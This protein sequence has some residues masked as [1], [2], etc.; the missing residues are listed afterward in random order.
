MIQMI[1]T[2]FLHLRLCAVIALFLILSTVQLIRAEENQ[3]NANL[4]KLGIIYKEKGLNFLSYLYNSAYFYTSDNMEEKFNA[5]I[6]ALNVC[7]KDKRT[8]EASAI[9]E[10]NIKSYPDKSL[11]V[12]NYY[13][14]TLLLSGNFKESLKLAEDHELLKENPDIT[15]IYISFALAYH[16]KY[17]QSAEILEKI[18]PSFPGFDMRKKLILELNAKPVSEKN[19]LLAGILSAI[20]PGSGQLY[21]GAYF[22]ALNSFGFT[23]LTGVAAA[24][25]WHHELDHNKKKRNYI[26]PI[27][28]STVFAIFY[29][30]NINN[31]VSITRKVNADH[32]N[33][34]QDKII[35]DFNILISDDSIF[36]NT[37]ISLH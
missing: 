9:Y 28:F 18:S 11:T 25:A 35:K 8:K 30:A 3:E 4:R 16:S 32:A 12:K 34:N 17:P 23:A 6:D 10:E 22:D 2:T 29:G 14:R 21:S 26:L 5:G 37:E 19:P 1:F 33:R 13:L 7:V 24:L 15:K 31:A 20:L 27:V 36:L